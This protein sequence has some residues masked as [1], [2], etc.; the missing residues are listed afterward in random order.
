MHDGRCFAIP[1]F[2]EREAGI[3]ML[4]ARRRHAF[5]FARDVVHAET[6][7]IALHD[8][9]RAENL[10]AIREQRHHMARTV[11]LHGFRKTGEGTDDDHALLMPLAFSILGTPPIQKSVSGIASRQARRPTG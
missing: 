7:M 3:D 4:F 2:Q 10:V 1:P 6:E 5:N 9:V 11:L 8:S